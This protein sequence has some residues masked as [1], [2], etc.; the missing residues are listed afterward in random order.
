MISAYKPKF[1]SPL[2]GAESVPVPF[3]PFTGLVFGGLP[4]SPS[5]SDLC[6]V[7]EG[8]PSFFAVFSSS[9]FGLVG[10]LWAELSLALDF[11][12]LVSSALGFAEGLVLDLGVGFG[13]GFGVNFGVGLGVDVGL[14]FGVEGWVGFGVGDGVGLGVNKFGGGVG[15]TDGFG[16]GVLGG[17]SGVGPGV[18]GG[19]VEGI[20]GGGENVGSG[21]GSEFSF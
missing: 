5:F 9:F 20:V 6:A 18:A 2:P 4:D 3:A 16:G 7:G 8:A 15:V 14:G 11:G 1:A 13:V 10:D 19:G 17:I 12:V 21:D